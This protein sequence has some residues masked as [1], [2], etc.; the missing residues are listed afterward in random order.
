MGTGLP[1]FALT[2]EGGGILE[3]NVPVHTLDA[4]DRVKGSLQFRVETATLIR[5]VVNGNPVYAGMHNDLAEVVAL[6][7]FTDNSHAAGQ[8]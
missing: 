5:Y 1:D 2:P 7:R 8:N 3:V 4:P 6:S